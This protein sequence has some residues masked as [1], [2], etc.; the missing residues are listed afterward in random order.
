MKPISILLVEDN[1]QLAQ[2]AAESFC[3]L[4]YQAVTV[5][6]SAKDAFE[7]IRQTKPLPDLAVLDIELEPGGMSG[8][9]VAEL[10][11]AQKDMPII[12]WTSHDEKYLKHSVPPHVS[13]L[14]KSTGKHILAHHVKLAVQKFENPPVKKPVEYTWITKKF[15]GYD[16]SY[17]LPVRK[18]LYLESNDSYTD[19]IMESVVFKAINRPLAEFSDNPAF[20]SFLRTQKKYVVNIGNSFFSGYITGSA[21]FK[22]PPQ[23]SAIFGNQNEIEIPISKNYWPSFKAAVRLGG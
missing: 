14:P 1:R 15:D 13:F 18:I 2:D 12:F 16:R 20:P 5:L 22:V 4:G 8:F 6:H 17:R 10:L 19:I 9:E 3:E 23:L 7:F 21:Y 11:L